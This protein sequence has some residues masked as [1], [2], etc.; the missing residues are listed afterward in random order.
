VRLPRAVFGPVER[1]A[2]LR[3]AWILRSDTGLLR[4]EFSDDCGG[5]E[6]LEG[7]CRDMRKFSRM[8]E[9]H[10]FIASAF[11]G[12]QPRMA[13]FLHMMRKVP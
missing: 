10:Y 1:S 9:K 5:R 11:L 7:S 8:T 3:L 13:C 12:H 4:A 2:F 6:F